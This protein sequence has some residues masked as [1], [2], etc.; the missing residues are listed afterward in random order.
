MKNEPDDKA[1]AAGMTAARTAILEDLNRR[2]KEGDKTVKM[3]GHS[4]SEYDDDGPSNYVSGAG[5]IDCPVCKSAKLRYSRA[6]YNGHVHAACM[7]GNCVR[8]ME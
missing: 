3:N 6:G 4:Q 2:H 5:E 1:L 7:N 8:W